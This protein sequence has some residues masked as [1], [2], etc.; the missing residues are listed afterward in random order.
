MNTIKNELNK[1][2]KKEGIVMGKRVISCLIVGMVALGLGGVVKAEGASVTKTETSVMKVE[3]KEPVRQDD[4]SE[5]KEPEKQVDPTNSFDVVGNKT[6][7]KNKI[8]SLTYSITAEKKAELTARVE[9]LTTMEEVRAIEQELDKLIVEQNLQIEKDAISEVIKT[10]YKQGKLSKD[11]SDKLLKRIAESKTV[12]EVDAIYG[13]VSHLVNPNALIERKEKLIKKIKELTNQGKLTKEQGDAFLKRVE[14][15][16]LEEWDQIEVE[17]DKQVKDNEVTFLGA[18]KEKYTKV[19]NGINQYIQQ[20]K[21]TKD[22]GDKFLAKLKTCQTV[23]ELD[24]LWNEVE[25]QVND[26]AT[27]NTK[28]A[29]KPTPVNPKLPQTGENQTILTVVIGLMIILGAGIVFFKKRQAKNK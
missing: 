10:F 28:P 19:E 2:N 29:P 20:G 4:S 25:K 11:E 8:D 15:G 21:L 18:F 5:V 17:V 14:A 27:T 23:E 13:E 3:K 22:Q 1:I 6:N 24:A 16:L 7:L 12:E 9:K 26:N